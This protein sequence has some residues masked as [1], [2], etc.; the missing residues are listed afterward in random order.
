[1]EDNEA[2]TKKGKTKAFEFGDNIL[3]QPCD[4]PVSL[5]YFWV[6]YLGLNPRADRSIVQMIRQLVHVQ[7]FKTE[8]EHLQCE[9]SLRDTEE[10]QVWLHHRVVQSESTA[11]A[12]GL[13][14]QSIAFLSG[15]GAC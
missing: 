12:A 9:R 15:N 14:H 1:M 2:T 5:Y 10:G 13:L 8:Q 4:T 7:Q 6:I 3:N 11:A